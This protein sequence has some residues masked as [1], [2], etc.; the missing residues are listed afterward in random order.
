MH[1][2][3]TLI[4]VVRGQ[5]AVVLCP[6]CQ[7]DVVVRVTV[8][9]IRI[10]LAQAQRQLEPVCMRRKYADAYELAILCAADATTASGKHPVTRRSHTDS[11][12]Q[13]VSEVCNGHNEPIAYFPCASAVLL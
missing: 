2:V 8:D 6:G 1:A 13:W 9:V 11:A 10:K 12:C 3:R 5:N 4:V 7:V